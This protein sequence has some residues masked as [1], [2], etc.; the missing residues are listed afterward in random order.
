MQDYHD[1]APGV[2]FNH[3]IFNLMWM[4]A[5]GSF[6]RNKSVPSKRRNNPSSCSSIPQNSTDLRS[7]KAKWPVLSCTSAL[8]SA[9]STLG[10]LWPDCKTVSGWCQRGYS[11]WQLMQS[12]DCNKLEVVNCHHA[13]RDLYRTVELK[14]EPRTADVS[15]YSMLTTGCN[16]SKALSFAV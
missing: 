3:C 14:A 1:Y 16:D 9:P 7:R 4:F 6:V 13:W 15:Q 5:C 8:N 12:V 11:W 2:L 10:W